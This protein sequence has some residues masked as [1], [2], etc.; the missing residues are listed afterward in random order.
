MADPTKA[1][2]NYISRC[3]GVRY[4]S[5]KPYLHRWQAPQRLS[6]IIYLDT[7]VCSCHLNFIFMNIIRSGHCYT[8]GRFHHVY[9]LIYT[10]GMPT[11][12][13]LNIMV[14]LFLINLCNTLSYVHWISDDGSRFIN[15]LHMALCDP[16]SGFYFGIMEN[17]RDK[18]S[19]RHQWRVLRNPSFYS[20]ALVTSCVSL[21]LS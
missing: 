5:I 20:I 9:P 8:S 14:I 19:S 10:L 11:V 3:Y 1:I 12:I 18:N 2:L 13:I 6:S 15:T 17:W 4:D 7:V 16:D 21:F